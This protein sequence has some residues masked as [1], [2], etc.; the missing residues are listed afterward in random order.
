MFSTHDTHLECVRQC[1]SMCATTINEIT[2]TIDPKILIEIEIL[3]FIE[4]ENI[5]T[6]PIIAM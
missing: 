1:N 4:N 2:S 3:Y 5:Y 6:T